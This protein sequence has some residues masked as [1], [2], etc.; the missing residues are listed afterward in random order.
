MSTHRHGDVIFDESCFPVIY[1]TFPA[2]L[3]W[4]AVERYCRQFER[5]LERGEPFVSVA[6]AT[7]VTERSVPT[8]RKRLA[9]WTRETEPDFVRLSKGD[10]RVVQNAIIRS[11]MTAINWLHKSPV[12]Q[13]WFT[14]AD[15][16][17]GWAI[18][19]LDAAYVFV[20]AAVR[21]RALKR[22]AR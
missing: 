18:A 21:D 17:M 15:Q 3:D 7:A 5:Y 6:D 10:A 19:R 4:E 14:S 22:V 8:V 20:P 16:A 1:Q 11:T 2:R 9:D 13:E 12:P